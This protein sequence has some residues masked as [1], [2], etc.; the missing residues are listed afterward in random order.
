LRAGADKIAVNTQFIKD[1]KF[2]TN[3][4]EHFGS[5]CIVLSVEAKRKVDSW[6]AY[7]DNGREHSSRDVIEWCQEASEKGIGEI[8]LTSVDQEGTQKGYDFELLRR[9]HDVVN[10]P[11]LISGG[12]GKNDDLIKAFNLGA[13]GVVVANYLHYGKTSVEQLKAYAANAG[14]MVR[15]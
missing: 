12:F 11:V 9:V 14:V 15:S 13:D 4:A 8:L 6:E 3:L 5:Q 7:F 2:I 10:V 1:P